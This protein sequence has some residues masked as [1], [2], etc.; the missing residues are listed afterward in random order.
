MMSYDH[1][2]TVVTIEMHIV[3]VISP[4]WRQERVSSRCK[5]LA[6]ISTL[7]W[8]VRYWTMCTF[9]GPSSRWCLIRHGE[10]SSLEPSL[11]QIALV[12]TNKEIVILRHVTLKCGVGL[13]SN[14]CSMRL[15]AG[16]WMQNNR[17]STFT[18]WLFSLF[19]ECWSLAGVIREKTSIDLALYC[20]ITMASKE[21]C[22]ARW[23]AQSKISFQIEHG[24]VCF[25]R[26]SGSS[27][28]AFF[29]S[30][31]CLRFWLTWTF[32]DLFMTTRCIT[33]NEWNERT[34]G[35]DENIWIS[36]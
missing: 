31:I 33:R 24:N 30:I 28:L 35:A 8:D 18:L 20:L 26:S 34:K 9:K 13:F 7:S 16:V 11:R 2:T 17:F 1:W 23:Q 4:C 25:S 32:Q 14:V 19:T 27:T 3:G 36:C 5:A 15:S 22:V 6:L 21:K 10:C 29:Q 12:E